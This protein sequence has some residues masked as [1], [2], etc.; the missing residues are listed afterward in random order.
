MGFFSGVKKAVSGISDFGSNV[1]GPVLDTAAPY[2]GGALD[3]Y[4]AT[5]QNAANL[6]IS[7]EQMDFQKMEA[8]K[9]RKFTKRGQKRQMKF[10]KSQSAVQRKFQKR[11]SNSQYQRAMEDMEKAGLNPILAYKQGGAGNLAGAAASAGGASATSPSGAQIP[12]VNELEGIVS[13]AQA[14]KRAVQDIK[15]LRSQRDQTKALTDQSKNQTRNIQSQTGLN[16]MQTEKTFHESIKAANE[17]AASE[18]QIPSAKFKSQMDQLQFL[19]E[20]DFGGSG[21]GQTINSL[22]LILRKIGRMMSGAIN[23]TPHSKGDAHP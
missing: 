11:M 23:I 3:Y 8:Q 18:Y 2:L 19:R 10:G 7:Q 1:I 16:R 14:A 21:T 15:N 9:A 20:K 6:A 5:Q 12:A 22:Q 13:S 4:G 17:A